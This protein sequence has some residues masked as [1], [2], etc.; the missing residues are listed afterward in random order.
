[1]ENRGVY[2]VFVTLMLLSSVLLTI[3]VVAQDI[4]SEYISFSTN[5]NGNYDIYMIDRH[6]GNLQAILDGPADE[7]HARWSPNGRYLAYASNEN[8][9]FY[10]IYVMDMR[11]Q[12]RWQL[13]DH[14]ANDT[15]PTWSPDGTEIAFT[16][17]RREK[18]WVYKMNIKGEK[19]TRLTKGEDDSGP[20]WSPDGEWIAYNTLQPDNRVYLYIVSADGR[21]Q[22]QLATTGGKGRKPAWSPDGKKI[23]FSSW[24]LGIGLKI[25][26]IDVESGTLHRVTLGGRVPA[27]PAFRRYSPAWSPDGKWIAYVSDNLAVQHKTFLYVVDAA[28]EERAESIQLTTH[29]S[30]NISPAWVPEPFFSV[31]PSRG[32]M[33]TLWGKLKQH[34]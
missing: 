11:T 3:N 30:T 29:L 15:N 2:T 4:G 24:E 6:G 17:N 5:R 13:T 32:K 22:K 34:E 19:L 16:S 8:A 7:I 25:V 23:A 10:D 12:Q 26:T 31:S 9:A 20:A 1:M 18:Y 33:T 28:G 14:A 27:G 21:K